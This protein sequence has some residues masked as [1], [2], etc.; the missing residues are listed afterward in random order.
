MWGNR[1]MALGYAERIFFINITTKSQSLTAKIDKQECI[2]LKNIFTR[3]KQYNQKI[4]QIL[5]EN[6]CKLFII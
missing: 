1:P 6:I 4:I 2:K 3:R 5:G